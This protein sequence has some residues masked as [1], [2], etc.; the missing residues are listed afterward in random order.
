MKSMS[1]LNTSASFTTIASLAL[2]QFTLLGG[3]DRF[4]GAVEAH[5]RAGGLVLVEAEALERAAGADQEIELVAGTD[6][7]QR[8]GIAGGLDH[9]VQVGEVE[10]LILEDVGQRLAGL[11]PHHVPC[12]EAGAVHG[13]GRQFGQRQRQQRVRGWYRGGTHCRGP[14]GNQEARQHGDQ[15]GRAG[16]HPAFAVPADGLGFAVGWTERPV[17]AVLV[18]VGVAAL[19]LATDRPFA[20]QAPAP[21]ALAH[22]RRTP[23]YKIT[24]GAYHNDLV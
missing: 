21:F 1:Y 14:G 16:Q 4:V 22:V 10:A 6:H 15:Q 18:E 11:Y 24:I 5:H 23:R 8:R 19:C 7:A 12:L 2:V 13:R 17:G 20:H 9:L 3:D